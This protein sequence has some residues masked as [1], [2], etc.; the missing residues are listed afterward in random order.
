M[1]GTQGG[2]VTPTRLENL[3]RLDICVGVP[4]DTP[5][6]FETHILSILNLPKLV[7]LSLS[8]NNEEYNDF[9]SVKPKWSQTAFATMISQSLCSL[10]SL[11]LRIS[12][13]TSEMLEVLRLTPKLTSFTIEAT[14]RGG[15]HLD[16]A[17]VLQNLSSTTVGLDH[18][19]HLLSFQNPVL[20]IT[21]DFLRLICDMLDTRTRTISTGNR[22]SSSSGRSSSSSN[23][24]R[25]EKVD[26][27]DED[28]ISSEL[29]FFRLKTAFKD[30]GDELPLMA[31]FEALAS[32]P[33]KDFALL[34][35]ERR[36]I[37]Y[38]TESE[39]DAE[40]G[41]EDSDA[42]GSDQFIDD[43]TPEN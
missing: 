9:V 12:I 2:V 18:L 26:G 34:C 4:L 29:E 6:E 28:S 17:Q 22:I 36:R 11:F 14:Y 42:G 35:K 37:Y 19:T 16:P 1:V 30:F 10:Q 5:A 23:S 20:T 43:G 32:L 33:G 31:R 38:D 7:S 21:N 3:T 41:R 40:E 27:G 39:G 24:Q 13:S 25:G 8:Y 15:R